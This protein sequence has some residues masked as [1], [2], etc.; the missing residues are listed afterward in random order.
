M[1]SFDCSELNEYMPHLARLAGADAREY[2]R[3]GTRPIVLDVG[4]NVGAV[5]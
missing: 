3:R 5:N 1:G 4:A 2:E